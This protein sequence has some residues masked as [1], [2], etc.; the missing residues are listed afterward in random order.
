[1]NQLIGIA[2]IAASAIMVYILHTVLKGEAIPIVLLLISVFLVVVDYPR[3]YFYLVGLVLYPL[4]TTI[5]VA[6]VRDQSLY[7]IVM[8]YELST[9][10][11]IFFGV[12]MGTKIKLWMDSK[13]I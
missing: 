6:I 2:V 8:F 7:P 1:M 5:N 10:A 4:T 13:N 11:M 12:F 9:I 3:R